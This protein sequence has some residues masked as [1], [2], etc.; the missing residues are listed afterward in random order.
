MSLLAHS[1]RPAM[2]A[3]MSL[4][5]VKRSFPTDLWSDVPALYGLPAVSALEPLLKGEHATAETSVRLCARQSWAII[6]HL[7]LGTLRP[8]SGRLDT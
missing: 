8:L 6:V 4:T 2:S 5:E 3:L 1:C 7:P